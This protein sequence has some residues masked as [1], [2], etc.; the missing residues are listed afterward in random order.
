MWPFFLGVMVHALV[1]KEPFPKY[2]N[3]AMF[4]TALCPLASEMLL[5]YPGAR[6]ALISG[7]ALPRVL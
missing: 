7:T 3:L 5:R 1:R 4:A 2:V 6:V